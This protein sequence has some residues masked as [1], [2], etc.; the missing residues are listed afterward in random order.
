MA[1]PANPMTLGNIGPL[2]DNDPIDASAPCRIDVGGTLDISSFHYP[3]RHLAPSTVNIA[4]DR[5][6]TASLRPTTDGRIHVSSAGFADAAFNPS[7]APYDHPLGLM[8]AVAD[9]FK[10]SGVQI[11]IDSSSP[12][13]SGLGGSS[14]A[15]VALIAAFSKALVARGKKGIARDRIVRLAHAIEQS[16]AGVPCGFQDQLAAAFGGVHAWTWPADP[17][18]TPFVGKALLAGKALRRL[19]HHL[20]VAYLGVTHTSKD[21]NTTWVKQFI[22]ADGRENW[23]AIVRLTHDFGGAI[24]RG[25]MPA[26]AEAM[27]RET[28]IRKAMTPQV[29]DDM[30]DRLA[31]A[32]IEAGCGARF[33]GAGGGGCLWAIGPA[34]AVTAL[35]PIW[36]KMLS[37]RPAAELLTCSVDANGVL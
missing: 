28:A 26:A 24:A 8:F 12:P 7:E 9:Y 25:D 29:L 19:N 4:L 1:T 30:G 22:R 6:T 34:D 32:A 3:L 2:L 15:A 20:L 33:T 21:V 5:R 23:H 27:N 14:V 35:K 11:R 17:G 36:A 10:A 37:E 18:L 16:V 31:A 13:K